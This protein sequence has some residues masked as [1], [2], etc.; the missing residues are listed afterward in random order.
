MWCC[1]QEQ[2]VGHEAVIVPVQDAWTVTDGDLTAMGIVPK[3]MTAQSVEKGQLELAEWFEC[4]LEPRDGKRGLGLVYD[5][6][7][8]G[9]QIVGV[10][11]G[12]VAEERNSLDSLPTSERLLLNDVIVMVNGFSEPSEMRQKLDVGTATLKVVRPS[13]LSASVDKA[14]GTLG[15]R[16]AHQAT[17]ST[18]LR[19]DS[20][21][22]G[23]GAVEAYNR[24]ASQETQLIQNDLI[25]SINGEENPAKMLEQITSRKITR[26][27]IVVLRVPERILEEVAAAA[28]AAGRTSLVVMSH[29]TLSLF[30][31]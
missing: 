28:A 12:G 26:L 8:F 13:R 14:Q 21:G 6:W 27:E 1:C 15:I 31:R 2:Q 19:I 16:V 10:Q 20:F 25:H 7:P 24:D 18:C 5:A 11:K 29:S 22:D 17:V 23:G 4:T 9:L 3:E 30:A